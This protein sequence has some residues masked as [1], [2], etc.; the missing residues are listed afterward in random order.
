VVTP[1]RD[2]PVA[3][4]LPDARRALAARLT[5][6]PGGSASSPDGQ[7]ARQDSR[8]N[9]L[10]WV[11]GAGVGA[12]GVA[13]LLPALALRAL[14]QESKD[15]AAGDVLVFATGNQTGLPIQASS[16]SPGSA[17][18]AFP[19]GKSDNENNLIELV[20]LSEELPAGLVGYS[21]ICTHLGCTVLA[22]LNNQGDIICPCHG[23]EFN[24]AAGAQVVRGPANRPLPSLPLQISPDGVVLAAG[25]FNG[26]VGPL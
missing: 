8:R 3:P 4:A 20:R 25:G 26:P 16:I 5:G 14:T 1:S 18:Q 15:V 13:L 19:Q 11:I 12:F 24:P 17:V 6:P 9:L 10:L 23:S 2:F 7:A 22:Q 21:A